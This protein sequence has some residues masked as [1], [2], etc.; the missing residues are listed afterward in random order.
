MVALNSGHGIVSQ[1]YYKHP[2]H[3][4]FLPSLDRHCRFAFHYLLY[5]TRMVG[6]DSETKLFLQKEAKRRFYF[7]K[8]CFHMM[9]MVHYKSVI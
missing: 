8:R 2:G 1:V 5:E 4:L 3:C 9:H 7:E 6:L